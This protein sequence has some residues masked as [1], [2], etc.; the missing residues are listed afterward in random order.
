MASHG[1]PDCATILSELAEQYERSTNLLAQLEETLQ[2]RTQASNSHEASDAMENDLPAPG[3]HARS[4][5]LAS[6]LTKLILGNDSVTSDDEEGD[7]CDAEADG[8]NSPVLRRG[9]SMFNLPR[10][11]E[12]NNNN[13]NPRDDNNNA[14]MPSSPSIR[15][16]LSYQPARRMARQPTVMFN[17]R[18]ASSSRPPTQHQLTLSLPDDILEPRRASETNTNTRRASETN[19]KTSTSTNT[20]INSSGPHAHRPSAE[21]LRIAPPNPIRRQSSSQ[22]LTFAPSLT[23]N[24]VS[25]SPSASFRAQRTTQPS[26]QRS[27]SMT[28]GSQSLLH[29]HWSVGGGAVS[30]GGGGLPTVGAPLVHSTGASAAEVAAPAAARRDGGGAVALVP[31]CRGSETSYNGAAVPGR[32]RQGPQPE[33]AVAGSSPTAL[34][35]A[36]VRLSSPTATAAP[37]L[38][39][40]DVHSR[41][42]RGCTESGGWRVTVSCAFAAISTE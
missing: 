27:D 11:R 22:N 8:L 1:S 18:D 35:P 21:T 33:A 36:S 19:N 9:T 38:L 10:G 30:G 23:L 14:L 12:N 13:N 5:L 17:R 3:A 6:K 25:L 16:A 29:A 4:S 15:R 34:P 37:P 24:G 32:Q 42:P 28:R 2:S 31:T 26:M 7:D 20:S 40:P 39:L 41:R